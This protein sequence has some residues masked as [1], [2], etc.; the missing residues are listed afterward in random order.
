MARTP[1]LPEA[2][3]ATSHAQTRQRTPPWRPNGRPCRASRSPSRESRPVTPPA[4]QPCAGLQRC[5]PIAPCRLDR[6]TD[7]CPPRTAGAAGIEFAQ[8]GYRLLGLFVVTGP[9]VG[10]GE[11]AER[12]LSF[13][14]VVRE[15]FLAPLDRLLP[16]RQMV[17]EVAKVDLPDGRHGIMRTQAKRGLLADDAILGVAEEHSIEAGLRNGPSVIGIVGDRRL[18]LGDGRPPLRFPL[19]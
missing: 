7:G 2:P 5:A 12:A 18:S 14:D 4:V 9:G 11:R 6:R 3:R 10:G 17:M 1:V 15:R 13:P 19:E 16:L 8:L